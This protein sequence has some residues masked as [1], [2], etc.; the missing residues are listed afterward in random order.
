MTFIGENA[1]TWRRHNRPA[2]II[3]IRT[4]NKVVHNKYKRYRS[5]KVAGV[6]HHSEFS[7]ALYFFSFGCTCQSTACFSLSSTRT[8]RWR[9]RRGKKT[10]RFC[11][12]CSKSKNKSIEKASFVMRVHVS[13]LRHCLRG[14]VLR[15]EPNFYFSWCGATVTVLMHSPGSRKETV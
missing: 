14:G 11:E 10:F 7:F 9:S 4:I 12:S 3:Y 15:R 6:Q 8:S 13:P 2:F 5:P 1:Y